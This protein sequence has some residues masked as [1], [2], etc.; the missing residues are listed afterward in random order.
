MEGGP[1]VEG[2]ASEGGGGGGGKSTGSSSTRSC[3][4]AGASSKLVL[5]ATDET[6]PAGAELTERMDAQKEFA[7]R[8]VLTR[9]TGGVGW[10][11]PR[12][13]SG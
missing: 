8:G 12:G 11:L 3:G 13:D 4:S 6:F 5:I 2:A 7:E 1:V 9:Q 10:R